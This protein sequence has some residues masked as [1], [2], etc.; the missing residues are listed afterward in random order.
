M[1]FDLEGDDAL[2]V[3]VAP[4]LDGTGHDNT[5]W[6]EDDALLAQ[7]G[8]CALALVADPPLLHASAGFVGASDGWQ[9]LSRHNQLTWSFSRAAPWC[10][11][12][13]RESFSRRRT[14]SC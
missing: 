1:S 8:P 14:R 6:T 2:V 3:L 12:P 4:H 9:D 10:T 13:E 11:T 5:G 7:H